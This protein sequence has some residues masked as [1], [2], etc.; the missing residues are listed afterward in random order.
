MS[1]WQFLL[2]LLEENCET[3]AALRTKSHNFEPFWW[4][5]KAHETQILT[6]AIISTCGQL[7]ETR[8]AFENSMNCTA[9]QK[10]FFQNSLIIL[11]ILQLYSSFAKLIEQI[12]VELLW[13][14]SIFWMPH[15]HA[16][17]KTHLSKNWLSCKMTQGGKIQKI[18]FFSPWMNISEFWY[19]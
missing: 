19:S 7:T 16:N 18:T 11:C 8:N 15:S 10:S 17:D 12:C 1:N 6:Y 5:C 2:C 9:K 14:R 3:F 4:L 13:F